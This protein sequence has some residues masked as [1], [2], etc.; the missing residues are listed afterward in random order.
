MKLLKFAIYGLL[1]LLSSA[2]H[3]G[4]AEREPA[5]KPGQVLDAGL[6]TDA[7]GPGETGIGPVCWSR[8]PD[9]T[10]DIGLLCSKTDIRARASYSRGIGAIP[11]S[12]APGNEYVGG[13]CYEQCQSNYHGAGP[14]CW[15]NTPS[16]WID[17][18]LWFWR[19]NWGIQTR[20]KGS[21]GRHAGT[22]PQSCP[23]GQQLNAGLCY[24]TCRPGYS[25]AMTQCLADCPAGYRN[26]GLT[27][28]LEAT[29]AKSS[30]VRSAGSFPPSNDGYC[31]FVMPLTTRDGRDRLYSQTAWVGTH[32]AY[33]NNSDGYVYA[34]QSFDVQRQ[35]KG[36][37]RVINLDLH[38]YD[39]QIVMCHENCNGV[40]GF[41][42][43]SDRKKLLDTLSVIKSFLDANRNEIVTL[44]FESYV[45]DPAKL[46]EV[47][48]VSGLTP[49]A[50]NLPSAGIHNLP[51]LRKMIADNKRLVVLS[52]EAADASATSVTRAETDFVIENMYGFGSGI[53]RYAVTKRNLAL[54]T[55]DRGFLLNHFGSVSLPLASM[56][57]N[58]EAILGRRA[59]TEAKVASG[60]RLPTILLVDHYHVPYCAAFKTVKD[61]NDSF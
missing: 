13:L 36:G 3:A 54:D 33:A 49:M 19:W 57:E 11:R 25:G 28:R 42:Y 5:C 14:V 21:Y 1:L 41:N 60:G 32:N 58:S 34:M 44:V 15:E 35:L 46:D 24:S 38:I 26:D 29:V 27:C 17:A 22:I 50:I 8:C 30:H 40:R 59:L 55:P 56:R 6:C 10:R 39:N 4:Y 61:I 48:Q 52:Q 12:C 9:G 7:C 18:G 53:N 47:F 51:T 23:A 43:G 45:K 31:D 2:S 37:V 16:G 20:G